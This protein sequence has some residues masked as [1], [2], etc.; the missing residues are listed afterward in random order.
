MDMFQSKEGQYFCGYMGCA[1][2]TRETMTFL[3]RKY[4]EFQVIWSSF[5]NMMEQVLIKM[6]QLGHF[7]L[8]V[9]LL[10]AFRRHYFS[11]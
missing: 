6:G 7:P 3:P 4:Q 8:T 9:I 2:F 5:H 11:P 1:A 10:N